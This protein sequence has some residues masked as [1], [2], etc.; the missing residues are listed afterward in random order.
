MD[1]NSNNVLL[2]LN[3]IKFIIS[4]FAFLSVFAFVSFCPTWLGQNETKTDLLLFHN[5]IK[6]LY[7]LLLFPP[8]YFALTTNNTNKPKNVHSC[9]FLLSNGI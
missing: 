8:R 9:S 4:L 7:I 6:I 3:S 5:N 1:L 2:V